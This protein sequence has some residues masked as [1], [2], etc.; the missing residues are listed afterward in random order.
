MYFI[1][2]R[3]TPQYANYMK[4]MG[5]KTISL[6][7]EVKKPSSHLRGEILRHLGG[8][9][10]YIFIKKLPLLPF[11]IAKILKSPYIPHS[12]E[13]RKIMKKH[14]C[15]FIKL[16]PLIH[17]NPGVSVAKPRGFCKDSHPLIPTKT[18]WINL[19]KSKKEITSQ[20]K[21]ETRYNIR[22]AKKNNLKIQ[23]INGSKITKKQLRQFY[24]LWSKNKPFN[25]L[26]RPH[27]NKLKYLVNAFKD[28][29]FLVLISTNHQSPVTSHY[30]STALNL[31]SKN[32]CFYWYG[33]SNKIGRQTGASSLTILK[34][35][36]HSKKRGAKIFDMGGI[37]DK[38][39]ARSQKGWKGFSHFKKSFGG[40]EVTFTKP[41]ILKFPLIS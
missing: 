33:A 23:I 13:L 35:I 34:S 11:S 14:N 24:N 17:R 41:L 19:E 4:K 29:C 5:W 21:K 15:L 27:F 18:I 25:W 31:C 3:Q 36:L 10:I 1:D 26:F 8:E 12:A 28:N 40:K 16:Q 9:R 6:T 37:Y 30:I 22:K 7:P 20:I 38:R 2:I 39:F 32:I